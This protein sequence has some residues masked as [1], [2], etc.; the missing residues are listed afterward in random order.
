[1]RR[2]DLGIAL[3]ASWQQRSDPERGVL[4]KA[5]ATSVPDSGVRPELTLRCTRVSADLAGWRAEALAELGRCLDDFEV[6]DEDDY[7]LDGRPVAYRRFAHRVAQAD[8]V[9]EQW[10]WVVDGLGVTL[11]G[12]VAR[13]DYPAYCDLFEAVAET[14]DPGPRAA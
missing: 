13:A 11:T 14:V 5:R 2:G 1:M 9:S 6:E 7:D 10:A 8:I 4:V 3:P 12:T